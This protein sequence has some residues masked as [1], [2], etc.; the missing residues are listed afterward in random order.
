MS[1]LVPSE[2][3]YDA[4]PDNEYHA[5]KGS[6]SSSGARK[7]L[8]PSCPA[9]FR[10]EQDHPPESNDAFDLGHAAHTLVLGYGAEIGE[11]KADGW[12][13]KAAKEAREKLRAEGKTPLLTKQVDQV[14]RMAA[15]LKSHPIAAALFADGVP[16]R[17][18]YWRDPET[19]VMLRA[20]PDWLPTQTSGRLIVT[21][22]K[23]AA[24]AEPG[25]FAKSA[26]KYG[27]HQQAAWYL[28]GIAALGLADDAAFVFVIQSKTPPYPVSVVELDQ[29]ALLLGRRLNRRA[30]D[31]F[32][33]CYETDTWPTWGNDVHLVSLP[34]WAHYHAEGILND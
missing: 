4:I 25:E 27:Y 6:L 9:I 11:V 20:R 7:L 22:Y 29:E 2:G 10:Y 33:E 31:I 8:P 19:G 16:E 21:D 3:L 12:T 13:T 34:T 32:A 5:D 26:A 18:M 30:I 14:N 1:D 24:G 17:S 28:D 15:S 23:T